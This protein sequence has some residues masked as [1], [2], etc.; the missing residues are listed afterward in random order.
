MADTPQ[1]PG[2]PVRGDTAIV[3]PVPFGLGRDKPQDYRE[4]LVALW[5]NRERL[6]PAWAVLSQGV[7]DGCSLGSR[8]LADD[9]HPGLHLCRRRLETL[10]AKTRG[11]LLPADLLHVERLR[12][13]P[14]EELG[15][16]PV[17]FVRRDSERGFRRVS[18][19]TALREAE[20]VLDGASGLSLASSVT[21]ETAFAAQ[22]LATLLDMSCWATGLERWGAARTELVPARFDALLDADLIL[23]W[24]VTAER[25]QPMLLAWLDEAK[26]RGARV[27]AL[28]TGPMHAWVPSRATSALFGT[29]IVDDLVAAKD[30]DGL[31]GCLLKTLGTAH[32]EH[33]H[34][35]PGVRPAEIA[36][37]ARLVGRASRAVSVCQRL[38]SGLG[39]LHGEG[40]GGVVLLDEAAN[41]AGLWEQGLRGG[42]HA[43]IGVGTALTGDRRVYV[44]ETLRPDMLEDTALTVLLPAQS[45]YEAGGCLTSSELRVRYSPPVLAPMAESA[46]PWAIFRE[47]ARARGE[48][49]WDALPWDDEAALREAIGQ[50]HPGYAGLERLDREGDWQLV[51]VP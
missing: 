34:A 9:T 5:N 43:C 24:G 16:L 38:P 19:D 18:W 13:L 27:V 25:D 32:A 3:S 45:L 29:R 33:V 39:A 37:L 51:E 14:V 26:R 47:L 41:A 1:L 48:A 50:A 36:W 8:G 2:P 4:A 21:H 20:S 30:L 44:A 28:G 6:G 35:G 10:A 15:R 42:E 31:L 17:P 40:A 22:A 11:P 23:L 7:C 49:G 46:A 12:G